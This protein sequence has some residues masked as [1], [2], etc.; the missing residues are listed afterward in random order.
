MGGGDFL[1]LENFPLLATPG[2][3]SGKEEGRRAI[4]GDY[5]EMRARRGEEAWEE[6]EDM[7][8]GGGLRSH[9]AERE[10]R[11]PGKEEWRKKDIKGEV[12]GQ[13]R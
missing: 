8:I 13:G 10:R 1:L 2:T 7:M 6:I 3:T 9:G 5:E 12:V 11:S 4:G